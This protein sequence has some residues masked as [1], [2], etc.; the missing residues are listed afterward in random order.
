MANNYIIVDKSILPDCYEKVIEARTAL[1][2]GRYKDVSEA[3]KAV[4]ISRSTYYKYKDYVFLPNDVSP[5]R[6]AV[7]VFSLAHE[8]GKLVEVLN[9]F[10][11]LGASILTITQNLP[12]SGKAHVVVSLDLTNSKSPVEDIIQRISEIKGASGTRLAAV[13]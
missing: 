12:I 5:H 6:K 1:S 9:V 2:E 7:I 3:A 13:D 8:A 4:G 10:S 11:S